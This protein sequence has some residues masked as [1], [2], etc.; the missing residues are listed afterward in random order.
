MIDFQ[1]KRKINNILYSKVSFVV[2]LI[3][4]V[5]LGRSTYN[6]YSKYKI[7]SDN[8]ASAKRDYNSLKARKD[9]LESEITRLKTDIG[10][11]EEIRSKFNVAKPGETVVTVISSGSISTST[12]NTDKG[13]W[14][15]FWDIF[16]AK[17]GSTSGGK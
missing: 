1:Q 2:L 5:F 15:S 11:E 14:S 9:M 10:I 13:F 7:S 17:G 6:I 8:Y 3:L 12:N 16:S 4:L